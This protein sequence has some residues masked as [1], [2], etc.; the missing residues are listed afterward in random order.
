MEFTEYRQQTVLI[1]GAASGIGHAQAQAFLAQ[2]AAVIAI[3][4]RADPADW[5]APERLTYH[6][7]DVRQPEQ[8]QAAI[9]AGIA[10]AGQPT[11]VCNT[12]GKLDGYQPSLAIDLATW[13]DILA[14]DL[15]SQFIVTNAVLPAMLERQHGV[16]VNMASIAGLVG[17]GGGAAYTA[18]KHA[19]IGYTKQLDLD[20]AAQGIRANCI[21]PGAIDTPMNAA[22]F[23]G[24]GQ[25]ARWV[26]SETPAKRWAQ[27]EEVADLTLFLASQHADYLH[28]T[29]IPIDGG[30]LEK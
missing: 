22:D 9:Q 27:P 3:D 19:I 8:L 23:A 28:G 12:A 20:Y 21:A 10:Q 6:V 2:G 24:D 13:Q 30:W 29:V 5:A 11:I 7:A 1:T 18:A 26:A 16:F 14:T 4:Q 15:T 25:M 17:G